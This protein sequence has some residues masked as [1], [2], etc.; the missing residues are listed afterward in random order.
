MKRRE[1]LKERLWLLLGK[2][3]LKF[4]VITEK[5]NSD[6]SSDQKPSWGSELASSESA[7]KTPSLSTHTLHFR[8]KDIQSVTSPNAKV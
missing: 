2:A 5:T 3:L 6:Y 8:L 4:S 7:G 1:N